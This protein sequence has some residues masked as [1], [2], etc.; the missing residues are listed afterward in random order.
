[1][2]ATYL[3]HGRGMSLRAMA[4]YAAGEMPKSKWTKTLMLDAIRV[5]CDDEGW[6]YQLLEPV[7]KPMRKDMIFDTFFKMTS[8]HHTGKYARETEFYAPTSQLVAL[9]Y[10]PLARDEEA[11]RVFLGEPGIGRWIRMD[12]ARDW[13][14]RNGVKPLNGEF[15]GYQDDK[16][17]QEKCL[18]SF[19]FDWIQNRGD[20]YRVMMKVAD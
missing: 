19:I 18:A 11:L 4:A 3:R 1:M 7:I 8:W 2:T 5:I 10:L 9:V 13:G 20:A 6:D 16:V 12:A 17:L 14:V 15:Y